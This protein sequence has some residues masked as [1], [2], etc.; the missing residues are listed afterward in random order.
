MGESGDCLQ[1]FRG[2]EAWVQCCCLAQ[3]DQL[4]IS[5]SFD[6]SLRMWNME[7]GEC[8]YIDTQFNGAI[9]SCV[10]S[11][12]DAYLVAANFDF[13]VMILNVNTKEKKI[14][15]GHTGNVWD[16]C[17]SKTFS[18]LERQQSQTF[19]VCPERIFFSFVLTF[20]I[21]TLKSKFAATKYASFLLKTQLEIAPLNCVSI[22]KHSPVSIFPMRRLGSNEPEIKS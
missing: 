6:P 10:L 21:I 18:L 2:H 12:N 5:G 7:T 3:N 16:C 13:S 1:E 9:S 8:L 20:N 17:L 14:L 4:L 19:P 22:Y 15:S 11:R